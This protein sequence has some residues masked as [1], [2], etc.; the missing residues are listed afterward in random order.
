M[1]ARSSRPLR[2]RRADPQA[3]GGGLRWSLSATCLTIAARKSRSSAF[4]LRG[5]GFP[6]GKAWFAAVRQIAPDERL[7]LFLQGPRDATDDIDEATAE[8]LWKGPW[9]ASGLE[10]VE[11]EIELRVSL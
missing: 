7:R 6:A 11:H 3:R 2:P 8:E 5:H 1:K 4:S 9:A 10:G